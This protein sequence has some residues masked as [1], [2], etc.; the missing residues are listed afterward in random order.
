MALPRLVIWRT[1]R[2]PGFKLVFKKNAKMKSNRILLVIPFPQVFVELPRDTDNLFP[3]DSE[4]QDL[5]DFLVNT[6]E[7]QVF[8]A[9]C[10]AASRDVQDKI[11]ENNDKYKGECSIS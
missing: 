2:R 7:N 6:C 5:V 4:A 3:D 1:G 11:I 10:A 9:E 8:T